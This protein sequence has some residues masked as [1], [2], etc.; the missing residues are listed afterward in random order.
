MK[1]FPHLADLLTDIP[2][3]VSKR[4]TEG[5]WEHDPPTPEPELPK[6]VIAPNFTQFEAWCRARMLTWQGP[7]RQ[8]IYVTDSHHLA[9]I[10]NLKK[11][12]IVLGYPGGERGIVMREEVVALLRQE[13]HS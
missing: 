4:L 7:Q 11:R 8:A 10:A 6:L 1:V 9:G 2:S 5:T 12:L 13:Q 3:Y